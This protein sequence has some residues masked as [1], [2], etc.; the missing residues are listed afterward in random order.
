MNMSHDKAKVVIDL[1]EY[2][3]LKKV[4]EGSIRIID[5]DLILTRIKE[6]FTK[7]KLKTEA[8]NQLKYITYPDQREN[9]SNIF[10][11]VGIHVID[12]II[13]LLTDELK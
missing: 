5:A 2:L 3:Q 9:I 10:A 8:L 13:K 11:E 6:S 1:D 12:Q 4:A 7:E